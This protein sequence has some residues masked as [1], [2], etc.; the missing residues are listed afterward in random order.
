MGQCLGDCISSRTMRCSPTASMVSASCRKSNSNRI[1]F[2][3]SFTGDTR[4]NLISVFCMAS[5]R[6]QQTP[7][8]HCKPVVTRAVRC[9]ASMQPE[10]HRWGGLGKG[11]LATNG[12][13]CLLH[14]LPTH[15]ALAMSI[16]QHWVEVAVRF[17]ARSFSLASIQDLHQ[18][19]ARLSPPEG[20]WRLRGR[21]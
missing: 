1:C 11:P 13:P 8:Q 15:P 21:C 19:P 10:P 18:E 5:N 7:V 2:A 12:S 14:V 9:S 16:Q 6:C 20:S 3:S 4:S 17:M